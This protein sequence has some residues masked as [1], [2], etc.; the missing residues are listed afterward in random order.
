[1]K[2]FI[3][4][5]LILVAVVYYNQGKPATSAVNQQAVANSMYSQQSNAMRLYTGE[6]P[7]DMH[8]PGKQDTGEK[9]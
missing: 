8:I 7:I 3:I 4:V 5:I 2:R 1:M 9:R 6:I